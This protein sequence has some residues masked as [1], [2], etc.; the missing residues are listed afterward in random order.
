MSLGLSTAL[1]LPQAEEDQ[2]GHSRLQAKM[3][4]FEVGCLKQQK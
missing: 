1:I 3:L 4:L 2:V